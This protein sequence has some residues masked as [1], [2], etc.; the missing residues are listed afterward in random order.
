MFRCIQ[1]SFGIKN[2]RSINVDDFFNGNPQNKAILENFLNGQ[3]PHRLMVYYQADTGDE[4]YM[5]EGLNEEKLI[6]TNGENV[7]LEKKGVFFI[8]N[9]EP[10]VPAKVDKID[11][12]DV[13][14]GEISPE[15]LE[16][17][18][19][20]ISN[21]LSSFMNNNHAVWGECDGEQIDEFKK[22]AER[23]DTELDGSIKSLK[24]S[25]E[26]CKVKGG[27][28]ITNLSPTQQEKLFED[29]LTEFKEVI[30]QSED[31][32]RG[33][34]SKDD[35]PD[36]EL[37][38]WRNRFQKLTLY[39][40][41]TKRKNSNF[42]T[43]HEAI[44][45]QHGSGGKNLDQEFQA[46][47]SQLTE[48]L[49]EAKDN[50]KYLVTLEK[51]IKPLKDG[52]PEE[53][54]E[55]LPALMNAIKM[56]HTIARYYKN[57][58]KLT[59]LFI[60]ITNA[61]IK[62]CKAR[63][64]NA[65]C[66]PHTRQIQEEKNSS[67]NAVQKEEFGGES[68]IW[69]KDP[70]ALIKVLESCIRLN[71]KYQEHYRNTK[72]S[73]SQYPKNRG[74]DFDNNS[75]FQKFDKFQ[76]RVRKL[77]EIFSI[78]KQFDALNKHKN[79][80]GIEELT[81]H[82]EDKF[83]NFKMKNPNP[84]E[85]ENE[86]EGSYTEFIQS[87]QK[88]D[89]ELQTF[90]EKNFNK[91]KVISYS[92][93][94]LKK[95]KGILKSNSI[96][97]KLESKY[98]TILQTYGADIDS[99]RKR[100][101][102][103]RSEPPILR[104]MPSE[105]GKIIWVRHL[106]ERLYG[107]MQEFPENTIPQKE[108]NKYI[109]KF[110]LIGKS[111][112]VYE[113][114]FT[115]A[116]CADIERAKSC[117]QTPL[118]AMKEENGVVKYRVNFEKD[119]QKLI[120][121][122]KALDREGIEDIP[123]S[124]KII[125]LQEE[126]FKNYYYELDFIKNEH[127]RIIGLIKPV[128]YKILEPHRE[129]LAFKM[130]PGLVTL[131]W[132]SMNIDGY[133]QH[134]QMSLSKLEQLIITIN[135][136]IDNRIENNLKKIGKVE[137][138]KLPQ[139]GKPMSLD[140][141]VKDQEDHITTQAMFLIS[142]NIE[143]ERAV[144]DLIDTVRS[145]KLE[146]ESNGGVDQKVAQKIKGYYFWYLY[147]AL[148]NSTQNSLTAMKNRICGKRIAG[149]NPNESESK[150]SL[151]PFF[152]VNILLKDKKV[153]LF[154]ALEDIQSAINRA[155][156]AILG[157]SKKLMKWSPLKSD[158]RDAIDQAQ[159]DSFYSIIAQDKEI[160][161]VI[162][163]LTGS[164][165]GTTD[166]VDTFQKQFK[167]FEPLWTDDI[168]TTLEKF[169]SKRP[170]LQ[171]YERELKNFAQYD[172]LIE[173]LAL[174]E[175][176]GAMS[177]KTDPL[178]GG[179]KEKCKEWKSQY[180]KDLHSKAKGELTELTEHIKSLRN[181]ITKP[182]TDINSLGMVVTT[183]EQ[184]R[185]EQ[186]TIDL[187]FGP[188]LEMYGLLD[189]YLPNQVTEKEELDNRQ[190]LKSKWVELLE[191]SEE[192]QTHL[193]K[194]Q[195]EHLKK[196]KSDQIR[197][198]D[199]VKVFRKK[200]E[201]KGP[202]EHGISPKDASDRLASVSEE[203][204]LKYQLFESNEKGEDLF[205]LV[206]IKYPDL[207][208][209]KEEINFLSEL[210]NLYNKV[211]DETSKWEEQ[212]WSEITVAQIKTWEDIITEYSTESGKM[213]R[214]LKEYQAYK[215]MKTKIE[216]YKNILPQIIELK[217]DSC[218]KERH[219]KE[220]CQTIGKSLNYHQPENFYFKELIQ[221]DLQNSM[222]AL[223]EIINSGK[224]QKSIEKNK[225]EIK[226]RWENYKFQ[227]KDWGK[228]KVK[229]L[230]GDVVL[231]IQE[232]LDND[233]STLS[234]LSANKHIGPFKDEVIRWQR[235]LSD[236]EKTLRD[237]INVQTSWTSLESVFSSGD[238]AKHL[239]NE[240]KKFKGINKNW[241]QTVMQQAYEKEK[242]LICCQNDLIK[243]ALPMLHEELN[244]CQKELEK[245][246]E[247]KRRAFPRFYFVSPPVLLKFLS[248]GSEPESVV[249]DLDKLF[250]AI[251]NASF[252]KTPGKDK[253]TMDKT[254]TKIIQ[255][256][257]KY[258]EVIELTEAVRCVGN[259]E[260]WLKRL[261][262]AMQKTIRTNL[263]LIYNKW[264]RRAERIDIP[265]FITSD[266]QIALVALQMRWTKVIQEA[267]EDKASRTK[268]GLEEPKSEIDGYQLELTAQCKLDHWNKLQRTKL[269]TLVLIIVYLSEVIKNS[270]QPKTTS[271]SYDWQKYTRVYWSDPDQ[272]CQ[273][274]ITDWICDYSNEYL[275]VKERL[276]ITPL[277]DR[278]Y[279]T[280]A[281]AMSMNYGGSPIGPAG[282]GKTETVKDL[283]NTL[284]ICVV[285]TNCSGEQRSG[286]MAKMFKGLCQSGQWGCF[287]E[288]N[289]IMSVVLSVIA[290]QIESITLAKKLDQKEF[291]FPGEV[292]KIP[293]NKAC[294]YFI[295][296]NPPSYG[297]RQKL[298]EN[299]K[300][301][302]R[303]ISMM[304]P[305]REVII[306]VKLASAGYTRHQ[307]LSKK[308]NVLYALC[309]EQLSKQRHYDFGLRNIL[310]VLRTAGDSL[311]KEDVKLI[312]K[313][314]EIAREK[315]GDDFT[316]DKVNPEK[317]N[318]LIIMMKSLR[319]MNLSKLVAQDVPLFLA[320]IDDIF[321]D[322]KDTDP[323]YYQEVEPHIKTKIEDLE[324]KNEPDWYRKIIQV[325]EGSLV[326]HGLMIIG[327]V[328]SG[329]TTI[330]KVLAEA[331]SFAN[332][333]KIVK[334]NPKSF[335]SQEMYGCN[336]FSG[337]WT[338]GV[339]SEI[340]DKANKK[341]TTE[342]TWIT[343]DGP[344][345][346]VWIESLNTV[347][348]DNRVLTLANGGRVFM[349]ET[350][351]MIFEVEN[352]NNASP[353]TVS[354]CGQIYISS[355]DLGYL[356]IMESWVQ[357]RTDVKKPTAGADDA[358]ITE[359]EIDKL[360]RPPESAI[361]QNI[362][363]KYFEDYKVIEVIDQLTV[364]NPVV[365]LFP[366]LK[367]TMTLNMLNGLIPVLQ[368]KNSRKYSESDYN[369]AILYAI[370]WGVSGVYEPTERIMVQE[371]MKEKGFDLPK[372]ADNETMYD[373]F[374]DMNQPTI[375]WQK[376]SYKE[377]VA[378]KK[379]EF[380]QILMPT[381][382]AARAE[383]LLVNIANQNESEI[384]RKSSLI[385]GGPGTAKTSSILMYTANNFGSE[386]YFNNMILHRINF[387]SATQPI[388]FQ[389]SI[390]S[391]CDTKIQKGFGPKDRKQ[392]T[393]FIDD[394]S[395]PEYNKYG[396]QVTLEI[397]RQ[398]IEEGY[399][400]NLEKVE[401][402]N[403][404][405]I[406][407]L[408]Y[409]AAMS[410][411]TGGRNEIPNRLK[412]QFFIFNM[413][414]PERIDII[415]NPILTAVF[416]KPTKRSDPG[417]ESLDVV[418]SLSEATIQL[419]KQV[420]KEIV[421][422][423][424]KFHYVFNL[425]DV[426]RI[427]KGMCTVS[428]DTVKSQTALSK[429]ELTPNAFM[430]ALWRHE[431]ERV[432][433]DK[434]IEMKEK[435]KVQKYINETAIDFF[436]DSLKTEDI[437]RLEEKNYYFC[438]FV[439][440]IE[441][442]ENDEI[443]EIDNEKK[444]E[445]CANTD[446]LRA[447][448]EIYLR[449]YNK[450][451]AQ[452]AMELVLFD[453]ALFHMQ[454][455]S[456]IIQQKR[457]SALLVGVGGSG[458]QSLTRLAAFIGDHKIQQIVLVKGFNENTLKDFIRTL[459]Q[460]AGFKGWPTTFIMTDAEIKKEEFL[461]YI[462]MVLS[463]GEIPGLIPKD[464]R[465]IWL[466][467]L[468]SVFSKQTGNKEP[469]Q[470]QVYEFFVNRLRDNLHIVLCFSPVGT[471]FRERARK[472]PALF[473]ECTIDWF[474]PWPK[475][476][477]FN[478]AK[479]QLDNF[480][481]LKTR[482]EI[483]EKELPE[484]MAN[485]HAQVDL[486]CDA[487]YQQMRKNV[488]ITPKSYLFFLK[489]YKSAYKKEM[490]KLSD[491]EQ[492][493]N[494]G[495]SKIKEGTDQ[496]EEEEKLLNKKNVVIK[497]M[498]DKVNK[499][500]EKINAEK[501][502]ADK[503]EQRVTKEKAT[504]MKDA[505][506]IGKKKEEIT[507]KLKAA[508]PALER[509]A[510]AANK[511]TSS[512]LAQLKGFYKF[513]VEE[514]P[515]TVM[516][517][518]EATSIL[519]YRKV[520]NEI[521]I[522]NVKANSKD[523]TGTDLMAS[524][525]DYTKLLLNEQGLKGALIARADSDQ[526]GLIND[527]ILE[528]L[529]PY[530]NL[531]NGFLSESNCKQS[532][533]ANMF[534]RE[535]IIQIEQFSINT[536]IVKPMKLD[537]DKEEANLKQAETKLAA[538]EEQLAEVRKQIAHLDSEH[539]KANGE[540][541][542]LETEARDQLKKIKRANGLISSLA[543]ERTRWKE[544]AADIERLKTELVGNIGFS[545]A[546][547]SYCGPF[548]SVFR[549]QIAKERFIRLLGEQKIPFSPTIYEKLVEFMVDDATISRWNI[550]GLPK[551]TLSIQN[552]IMIENSERYPL[553]I[554]PQGQ[555]AFW[556]KNKYN[557]PSKFSETRNRVQIVSPNEE[558]KV[559]ETL[560]ICIEEGDVFILEG[561]TGEVDP[562]FDPVLEKQ[563][564]KVGQG[565]KKFRVNI[566]DE[567]VDLDPDFK[568]FITCKLSTPHFT[569]EL[570]AKT[571]IID[572]TVT[573]L[574]LEQQLLSVVLSKEQSALEEMLNGLN[575]KIASNK[576]SLQDLDAQLLKK[577]NESEGSLLEDEG[578]IEILKNAKN[579]SRE[580]GGQLVEAREKT[581]DIN[582]KR[583]IYRPVAIRGSVMYFCMIEIANVNWMYNS[584]LNQFLTLYSSSIENSKDP[585][586]PLQGKKRVDRI[587]S[588]LT[589]EV[590]E[591]V[592]RGL[593]SSHKVS[594]LLMICFKIMLTAG[595]LTEADVN[596]F[597]K[598]A[599][600]EKNTGKTK[601]SIKW[602]SEP[603]WHNILDLSTHHFFGQPS[604]FFKSL[605]ES[606][607][608]AHVNWFNWVDDSKETKEKPVPEGFEE[609]ITA[610]KN[611]AFIRFCLVKAMKPDKTIVAANA[612][613]TSTLQNKDFVETPPE[614][615][616]ALYMKSSYN[617]PV[618][619]LLSEGADP[620]NG[621]ISYATKIK[622]HFQSVSMGEGQGEKAESLMKEY[623]PL[624]NWILLQNCHL[625]IDFMERIENLLTD[626]EFMKDCDSEFRIWMSCEPTPEFPLGL[627]QRCLKV[628]NEPP[629][630]L[631][632]GMMKTFKNIVTP[633]L[634]EAH[635]M[636]Q[637]RA[638]CYI[639]SFLHS[640]MQERR[641]F[642][643]IGWCI[644]YE[645]NDSDLEASLAYIDK[646]LNQ[647][648]KSHGGVISHNINPD[649]NVINIMVCE[650]Q[651]GGKVSDNIDR[652]ILKAYGDKYFRST[653]VNSQSGDPI[654]A[655]SGDDKYV[656]PNGQEHSLYEKAIGKMQPVD[657]S[658]IFGMSVFA[659]IACRL[660]ETRE[661]IDTMI[662]TRPKE[663]GVSA[664]GK[665]KEE[666]IQQKCKVRLSAITFSY[667]PDVID[668]CV[669]NLGGPKGYP[670]VTK[671]NVQSKGLNVPMNVFLS[672]ELQ[673]M[674]RIINIIK[675]TF[676]DII[677]AVDGQILMTPI[678]VDSI[679]CIYNNKV[680]AHWLND[681]SGAQISWMKLKFTSWYDSFKVR[682]QTLEE[683][684]RGVRPKSYNLDHFFNPQGLLTSMKQ[685][686]VRI[687]TSGQAKTGK[688]TSVNPDNWSM[689]KVEYASVV[690]ADDSKIGKHDDKSIPDGNIFI[691]G[692]YI[693]GAMFWKDS[694]ADAKEKTL[695]Y[696]MPAINMFARS[697]AESS[698]QGGAGD[699]PKAHYVCPLYKYP[700]R[701]DDYL[702]TK[703]NL[704]TPSGNQSKDTSAASWQLKGVALLCYYEI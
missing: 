603:V 93:K 473:N 267:L 5:Q 52:T 325:Y 299:L 596:M 686:I 240:A 527:E 390:E 520:K 507:T 387:S 91:F 580:I 141:F 427:F 163:L 46:F 185:M 599:G 589:F 272:K 68:T 441:L 255:S 38:W 24:K 526:T 485:V 531:M 383:S 643:P 222:E 119:I 239:K 696:P 67:D 25:M 658:E 550:E 336:D 602:L 225:E 289:R 692:L 173:G 497:E 242:V 609:M 552:G 647:L 437:A 442:D 340:W 548:G 4:T 611:A 590:F 65:P 247:Q 151:K 664:G 644:P 487:Y 352:L 39:S 308:F 158:D 215:D 327:P 414:L 107:P 467:E 32:Q 663:G 322:A 37:Q 380:S 649:Y 426:S 45:K 509:A 670:A 478:V 501:A 375:H 109:D 563:Y 450:K 567:P 645:F 82:F 335:T 614:D 349:K 477:L 183:L 351:K 465:E 416:S 641:K 49:S 458:R 625:G 605:P 412:R 638:L 627:L 619:Y 115:R 518:M 675:K 542:K 594:F 424:A 150:N 667:P 374:I 517:L 342:H 665:S 195:A 634:F 156:T 136:I 129:D 385:I 660:K 260:E 453:D 492:K 357:Q 456:R 257:G 245:Y 420:K 368:G 175:K 519:L 448:A 28:D 681:P 577:L 631:K 6:L 253:T 468:K 538:S 179:L 410:H 364:K 330:L 47:D 386:G 601:P 196:L 561:I 396:D 157:C 598:G 33:S 19:A 97:N 1:D 438:T 391:V 401:R 588:Y 500:L 61:M 88:L 249:D 373:Y 608:S 429:N 370:I 201:E 318:E 688:N 564:I 143:I 170:Q 446:K 84:L 411:P 113:I 311:R 101:E 100:F 551:D 461:E 484:W 14:F 549:D 269:E 568:L 363:S 108:M 69:D 488:S 202:K 338:P 317:P 560:K 440:P 189:V 264:V 345:D 76:K 554:D 703:I 557:M 124:A 246:L 432:F 569:P 57:S 301:L 512:D 475:E 628:T 326:R 369:K 354:R 702:V 118:M 22:A 525:W 43:I 166:K 403:Q 355:T 678:I 677:D 553:M 241:K 278:C 251:S 452:K 689:D 498:S 180:S 382:D 655:Q 254:I 319:D 137:L 306:Q 360:F 506:N 347:L 466:G 545:N 155:A 190:Q 632:A 209:T 102:D 130:R 329:K 491:S 219:W 682:N 571:T 436:R 29:W 275:G 168:Q 511:I 505:E 23:F 220:L 286:D 126:K 367:M 359:K 547:I 394:F 639:V 164:F 565:G 159:Q 292:E 613:I 2:T 281:Q 276:C 103:N 252:G 406:E 112:V 574:G 60:K 431:C 20:T 502:I 684:M 474:L 203:Y 63:I 445:A 496:V 315:Y 524:S 378:P 701:T 620:T 228:T 120:R 668:K 142:K 556:I 421:P 73:A 652:D 418:K 54:I 659:D 193:Q 489:S 96:K 597:L 615:I 95:L 558:K 617:E 117:L 169:T 376:F 341:T 58:Q 232:D 230:M 350:V 11:S 377:W 148:L 227:F 161:K 337:E 504:I 237:W 358:L 443:I 454:R 212:V 66:R 305:N 486:A 654:L 188:I 290:M 243:A 328:G 174:Q 434:L 128:M 223:E 332:K 75:I 181:K 53:I 198:A 7:K 234:G 266:A 149:S 339:F 700:M 407:N 138:V 690:V 323:S 457:S 331:L 510:E 134:V 298:P 544:G 694:L 673:R 444:Y 595:D 8:R 282:T 98:E 152:E 44:K 362:L 697:I 147:Q 27:E 165:K 616:S 343:C 99:I 671:G 59:N 490:D 607:V 695:I 70:S 184:I 210:Y 303:G 555:G 523:K 618:L 651:Y 578:L 447:Q 217:D 15:T 285:V 320:L 106:F 419:W 356:P 530:T 271:S 534:I 435:E 464:E 172:R 623:M 572:F 154:P 146:G 576:K 522:K 583:E 302:F 122:A 321:P 365:K 304:V 133:L 316:E 646:Y 535:W 653:I 470:Q 515:A 213:K 621:I 300:V 36:M 650:I 295:T 397:V 366:V 624:G 400:Y 214:G 642:G 153:V 539:A 679:D 270:I 455:I 600:G 207:D 469:S 35:G 586:Q 192:K 204:K 293:L 425:R 248:Q 513:S 529:E 233:I 64:E 62:N 533:S 236:V 648:I 177:F 283:G 640:L 636:P 626:P 111:L 238:I 92:L 415:F 584:S 398:L 131:T 657:S 12:N 116:W 610:D 361:V 622:K 26:L 194:E 224:K 291:M 71:Q 197:L 296:M 218:I 604:A 472:F 417:E 211:N 307:E 395:M 562:S 231:Q 606:I 353:A 630:G 532:A 9:T 540:K 656:L 226:E 105:A 537:L 483:K 449:A 18:K 371:W 40:E 31:N 575:K 313:G 41:V 704:K 687:K 21:V 451:N 171:D 462:N 680:P 381:L 348:D 546:F 559:K 635:E 244:S 439:K 200:F 3:G 90:I 514:A 423:P 433:L 265:A 666:D 528:L 402:G 479:Q 570:S 413:T 139:D 591:Y 114:Y 104:N 392:M 261:E 79:L 56:I 259:I 404:K 516:Y 408:R 480:P 310:S 573:Q 250:D 268:K 160:V 521:D 503:K 186:A 16:Q 277:T 592:N 287:D 482:K 125:L 42:S 585:S 48:K 460:F 379:I 471:K 633:D 508:L 144:D 288:F 428:L 30:N 83:N 187:K 297:G 581:D 344:V 280:L 676:S 135:D 127:E 229:V 10:G 566:G 430:V 77:I 463:T 145:Y 312:A 333:T 273:I 72:L 494:V 698:G 80:D 389:T 493:Y 167:T 499:M 208:T 309:E 256:K 221:A 661:M 85:I 314:R 162:L 393:V 206:H 51:F 294:G 683:W 17:L 579:Q 81:K 121:E 459:F 74:W 543:D 693:E 384:S 629:K 89:E 140:G 536:R 263:R 216:N 182:I 258:E 346:A 199:E 422:T 262:E 334:L 86:F 235:V 372:F 110:N 388:H 674:D 672:Q 123:E 191:I 87:I 78:V 669:S 279:I 662:E 94:L 13:L 612:F 582:K 324:L 55:T 205:G 685:E 691:S 541:E 699:P 50:V 176:I 587:E 593:F 405:I 34:D 399:F 481:D 132:T 284:G 476:A 178:I 495:L 409:V 637:W 274:S